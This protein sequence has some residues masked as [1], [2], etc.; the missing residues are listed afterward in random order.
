[1]RDVGA[2]LDERAR[3]QQQ[4]E[5]FPRGQGAFRV[6]LRHPL[7]AAPGLRLFPAPLEFGEALLSVHVSSHTAAAR[8]TAVLLGSAPAETEPASREGT[9]RRRGA[10]SRLTAPV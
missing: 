10:A 9:V 6:D 8:G 2:D 5:S 4:L 1:M 7:G 3:I